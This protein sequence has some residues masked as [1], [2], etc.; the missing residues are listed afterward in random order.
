MLIFKID[1]KIKIIKKNKKLLI[2]YLQNTIEINLIKD[3]KIIKNPDILI[4]V[5]NKNKYLNLFYCLI[6]QKIKGLIRP[7]RKLIYLHG[8]GFRFIVNENIKFFQLKLGYSHLIEFYI[9]EGIKIINYKK[10]FIIFESY[11]LNLLTK[12]I[13]FIKHFKK[14]DIYKGKGILLK[15]EEIKLKEIKKK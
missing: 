9:P 12:F 1:K 6:K 4:I 3:I 5:S 11:D 15:N 13:F 7:F 8:V 2:I 10:N 14:P